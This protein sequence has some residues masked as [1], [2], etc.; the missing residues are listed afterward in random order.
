MGKSGS[1][2]STL[3]RILGLIDQVSSGTIELMERDITSMPESKKSKIRLEKLGYVFQ[4]YALLPELTAE[5][6]VFLPSK[7]LGRKPKDYKKKAKSLLGMV[8]LND[9]MSHRPKQLSGGQQQRVAIARALV[10]DPSIIFAD[11]PTANL[12]SIS[13]KAVMESLVSLNKNLSTTVVFVSHDPDDQKYAK[14]IIRLKDG[15]LA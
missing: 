3:L 5:E 6:N 9:R 7:M 11:E 12:D 10:N 1:G 15:M 4:E 2:K 14:R 13:G 8:G